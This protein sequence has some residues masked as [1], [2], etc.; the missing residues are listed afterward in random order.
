[1]D[2]NE[3]ENYMKAGKIAANAIRLGLSIIREGEKAE[4]I[5]DEI[6]Y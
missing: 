3:I 1:M 6:E 4:K 2:Q 5:A